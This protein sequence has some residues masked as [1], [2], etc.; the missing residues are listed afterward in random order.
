LFSLNLRNLKS[1]VSAEYLQAFF[2]C[3]LPFICLYGQMYMVMRNK[4][5]NG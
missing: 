4:N 3:S 1:W 5:L 2:R